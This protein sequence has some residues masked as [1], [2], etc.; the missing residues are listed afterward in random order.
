MDDRDLIALA[1]QVAD[2]LEADARPSGAVI[3]AVLIPRMRAALSAAQPKGDPFDP[4]QRTPYEMGFADGYAKKA[5]ERGSAEPEFIAA[6]MASCSGRDADHNEIGLHY[7]RAGWNA[8]HPDSAQARAAQPQ[9]VE[10]E[11][12]DELIRCN[13][14]HHQPTYFPFYRKFARAIERAVLAKNGLGGK[15]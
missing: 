4:K 11:Q 14:A 10:D 13:I 12:I 5:D 9:S 15:Q 7:F 1:E 8:R 6:Y 3:R 2:E